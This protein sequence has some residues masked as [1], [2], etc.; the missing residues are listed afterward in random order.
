[1]ANAG[2]ANVEV[3]HACP[4]FQTHVDASCTAMFDGI[5]QRLLQNTKQ[6]QRRMLRHIVSEIAR[7]A[8][9]LDPV[10]IGHFRRE[11]RCSS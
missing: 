1:M 6:T 10:L 8:C 11:P 5:A 4:T 2:V 9:N 3:D 7:G